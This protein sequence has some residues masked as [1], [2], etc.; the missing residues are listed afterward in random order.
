M[1]HSL[2]LVTRLSKTLIGEND[3]VEDLDY[4]ENTLTDSSDSDSSTDSD[5]GDNTS[6]Y[7]GTD[8]ETADEGD[9]SGD[10]LLDI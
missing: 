9:N 7:S 3:P 10:D 2:E 6:N 4:S 1:L 8:T 5:D